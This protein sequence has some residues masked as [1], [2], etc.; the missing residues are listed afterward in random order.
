MTP[1]YCLAIHV[2]V[3][4]EGPRVFAT[5]EWHRALE[6]LRD[7]FAGRFGRFIVVAPQRPA[8]GQ[9]GLLEIGAGD[10]FDMRPSIPLDIGKRA[11]WWR[12]RRRWRADV[13]AALAES[14]I[15]HTGLGDLLRPIN[16]DALRLSLDAPVTTVFVRDTDTVTQLRDLIAAGQLRGAIS[17]FSSLYERLYERAM[18][19]AV[20]RAHLSL[21]KGRALYERYAARARN[22]RMFQNTSYSADEIAPREAIERRIATIG[23]ARPVRFV[24]C[25]RLVAR[26]GLDHAIAIVGGAVAA[27]ADVTFDLIGEG[28][29]EPALRAQAA[30]AGLGERVRFR[31][32]R[33]YG[34]GLIAELAGYDALLFTPRSEDTPRMIFDGYAAGLPLVAYDIPYVV[35]RAEEERA[36]VT[37]P[38]ED[39]EAGARTLARL[40]AGRGELARL[41]RTAYE[42]AHANTAEAWYRRRAEWTLEAHARRLGS[43]VVADALRSPG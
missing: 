13:A 26:K 37:I 5:S 39:Q 3:Y 19:D 1:T 17:T 38:F 10:G 43:A 41:A 40:A 16:L 29:D 33:R 30:A 35:E 32:A 18:R 22:P 36:A 11:Y 12:H 9:E 31:G 15:G 4:V 28:A 2:P 42:A 21:L 6:L 14:E 8:E 23:E 27:G 7:S 24:Y 34:R 20:A 25:G